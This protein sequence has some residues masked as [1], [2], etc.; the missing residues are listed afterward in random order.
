MKKPVIFVI[1]AVYLIPSL[2]FARENAAGTE[3]EGLRKVLFEENTGIQRGTTRGSNPRLRDQAIQK[4]ESLG[5]EEAIK[6]LL[7][8]LTNSQLDSRLKQSALV[9]LGKIGTASAIEAIKK[10]EAWSQKRYTE[11]LPFQMGLQ[12]APLLNPL[13]QTKDKDNKTWALVPMSRYGRFDLSLTSL[14]ENNIW[15]EPIFLNIP[16]FP[17]VS[18]SRRERESANCKLQVEGDVLKITYN[19]ASYETRISDQLKDTDKDGLPDNV[20]AQ[21]LTDPKN[22][23]SDADGVSDGKDSNPLTP[24]H[25]EINDKTEI[26]QAAFSA[27]FATAI[28]TYPKTSIIG[29]K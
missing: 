23:D 1:L 20:E 21:L 3:I 2:V 11:P 24:K 4:L 22:P 14:I 29:L 8:V 19:N 15:S 17:G 10:F 18:Q 13:A 25:K 9:S 28:R 16:N 7:E 5:S 27:L 12:S 6:V 26:R